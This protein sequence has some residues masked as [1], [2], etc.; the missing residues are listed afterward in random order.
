MAQ[1]K[2]FSTAGGA[3]TPETLIKRLKALPKEISGKN[4]GP[5]RQVMF[6]V[7]KPV[8][9]KAKALAPKKTGRLKGAIVKRRHPKPSEIGASEAYVVMVRDGKRD[10]EKTAFYWRFVHFPTEKNP[11]NVPFL[12]LAFESTKGEQLQTFRVEFPKVLANAER[13]VQRIK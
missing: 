5:L 9:E 2:V 11:N 6:K 8:E 10:N 4:G 12:A 1:S 7:A 13:R 3:I